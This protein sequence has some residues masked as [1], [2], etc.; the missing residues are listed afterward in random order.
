MFDVIE[1]KTFN[2]NLRESATTRFGR[3]KAG[4][5]WQRSGFGCGGVSRR[6]DHFV[7]RTE[8]FSIVRLPRS[9]TLTMFVPIII[10]V[11]VFTLLSCTSATSNQMGKMNDS[12]QS[13]F[14]S[15]SVKLIIRFAWND[16]DARRPSRI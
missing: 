2:A 15:S 1:R 8:T 12:Y 11:N 14:W 13:P 9:F 16:R 6:N 10:V 4:E 3:D 7:P 5:M